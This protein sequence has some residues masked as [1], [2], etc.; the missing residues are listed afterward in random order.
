[1]VTLVVIGVTMAGPAWRMRGAAAV[2]A[3]LACS[4]EGHV[5]PVVPG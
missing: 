1:M 5:Q 3:S 4:T 2:P